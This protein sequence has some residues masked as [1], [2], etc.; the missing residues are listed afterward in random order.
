MARPNIRFIKKLTKAQVLRREQLRDNG[1]NNRIR[2]RAHAILF[3]FQETPVNEL[4]KS[5]PVRLK[6]EA[7]RK[8]SSTGWHAQRL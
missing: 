1:E 6:L 8:P 7:S 4:V 5:R 3:S 2:H